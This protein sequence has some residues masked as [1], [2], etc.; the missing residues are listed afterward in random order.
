MPWST[1]TIFP[2]SPNVA[3]APSVRTIFHKW[4]FAGELDPDIAIQYALAPFEPEL[5]FLDLPGFESARNRRLG[6]SR[7][8]HPR[9]GGSCALQADAVTT[10]RQFD[11]KAGA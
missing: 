5:S 10:L 8:G 3:H 6:A 2:A 7:F 4:S 11:P 1:P 9:T